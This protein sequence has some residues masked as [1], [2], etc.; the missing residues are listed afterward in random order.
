MFIE[1]QLAYEREISIEK[2]RKGNEF[3]LNMATFAYVAAISFV[4]MV[5]LRVNTCTA[6]QV[7]VL[8]LLR[9][10]D[11]TVLIVGAVLF[12]MIKTETIYEEQSYW[13][14]TFCMCLACISKIVAEFDSP[15]KFIYAYFLNLTGVY[16]ILVAFKYYRF[17]QAFFDNVK[18][19]YNDGN[20]LIHDYI[21]CCVVLSFIYG[22]ILSYL[23]FY[24]SNNNLELPENTSEPKYSAV[25]S[26][27]EDEIELTTEKNKNHFL[28]EE[29]DGDIS[30]NFDH[31]V[32][33]RKSDLK[34]AT[35]EALK[36]TNFVIG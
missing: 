29:M 33:S 35:E 22:V 14:L 23:L 31:S 21:L 13:I 5:V 30:V 3:V 20:E 10:L 25:G 9:V 26:N 1:Y 6:I 19:A 36:K 15:V 32:K 18:L 11:Q 12:G 24:Y 4:K 17:K 8:K 34:R 16:F 2:F 27:I 28:N 7:T